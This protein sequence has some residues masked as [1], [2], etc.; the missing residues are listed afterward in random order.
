M[1]ELDLTGLLGIETPQARSKRLLEEGASLSSAIQAGSPAAVAAANLPTAAA[2]MRGSVGKLFGIDTRSAS[3]KL[4]EQLAGTDLSTSSGI[5][6][7]AQ[8]AQQL[9][10]SAQAVALTAKAGEVRQAEQ[11]RSL[12]RQR[13]QQIIDLAPRTEDRAEETLAL[14]RAKFASDQA[15]QTRQL[16]L[17]EERRAASQSAFLGLHGPQEGETADAKVTEIAQAI[18]AGAL[19]FAEGQS[20]M[21]AKDP[22]NINDFY[23]W[24]ED[25]KGGTWTEFVKW[26]ADVK[27]SSRATSTTQTRGTSLNQSDIERIESRVNERFS[28]FFD[29]GQPDLLPAGYDTDRL[30]DEVRVLMENQPP[31][32]QITIDQ[33]INIITRELS[34]GEEEIPDPAADEE[35]STVSTVRANTP[36][37]PSSNTEE[38]TP[39]PRRNTAAS[40]NPRTPTNTTP[41]IPVGTSQ[42]S[43]RGFPY[44]S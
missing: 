17:N 33:A 42:R 13:E 38:E 29:V 3:E 9:G 4:Q 41:I 30:T 5:S 10:M 6:K 43:G 28:E 21:T 31:G 18:G 2:S 19:T 26:D 35:L 14:N 15:A 22:A 25:N 23:A 16:G 7:A 32:Q 24:Q 20:I 8:L 44:R 12:R 40:R 11:D 39:Q 1:A 36:S 37:A 34:S 27:A